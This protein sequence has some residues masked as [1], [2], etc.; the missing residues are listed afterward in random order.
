ME[1]LSV[2]RDRALRNSILGIAIPIALQ[3]L[4]TY[5]TSMMDTVMLGQLGEV[6]LSSASLANQFGL[7]FMV[8]TFGVASGT[9]VLLSQYWG[10]G[11]TKSIRSI[12]SI[13]Y[14]VALVLSL[15]FTAAAHFFPEFILSLFSKDPAVI[16]AGS[17]YL[18]LVCFSYTL[19]GM[20]NVM[21]MS[22][23]SFGTVNISI[24]VYIIS[25][26]AN[27]SLNWVLIFGK[28][29]FPALGMAGAAIATIIA[30]GI[31]MTIAV[32][33]I[34]KFEKKIHYTLRDVVDY[35]RSFARDFAINVTPVMLNELM[36]SL[37]NS[38]VT[39]VMGRMGRDL[40][41]ANAIAG[42][43][44]QLTQVFT[45]GLS[46]AAAVV[47]GNNI[48]MGKVERTN[49]ISKAL[50]VISLGFGILAGG[51]TLA[52]R[53]PIIGLYNIPEATKALTWQIMAVAALLSFFRSMEGVGLMGILR[54]GG[55]SRFVLL[56]DVSFLWMAAIPL[57]AIGGLWL[58]LAAPLVY[59][60]LQCDIPIKL[61]VALPRI[62][63]GKW[64][65]DVTRQEDAVP[66]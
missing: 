60:L 3:N 20:T 63:S 9:N 1:T 43:T 6:E 17:R 5:L 54:G 62:W 34:L 19:N 45:I 10:K 41:S 64:V 65:K 39:A 56:C 24:V 23:R 59:F 21:L 50:M 33:Y 14:R 7:I 47:I 55:D 37:G 58:Q 42:L 31:E 13:M 53:G 4:I 22:L 38:V 26:F 61:L 15:F 57:G 18:A 27:V 8:L 32:V 49:A 36:W 2:L 28:L 52:L 29:G 48:G 44:N 35:D 46:N 66:G 16:A 30:R 51:L 25:L 11:D 12:L 40:V